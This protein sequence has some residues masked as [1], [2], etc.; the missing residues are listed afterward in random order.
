MKYLVDLEI[1]WEST[2]SI[3]VEADSP[4]DAEKQAEEEW[5]KSPQANS[6]TLPYGFNVQT[7]TAVASEEIW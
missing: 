1:E 7:V 3:I 6:I 4:E 2:G 5:D